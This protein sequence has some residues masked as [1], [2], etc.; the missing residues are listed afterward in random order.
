MLRLQL[1]QREK[2]GLELRE[3][4]LRAQG[5]ALR[6]LLQQLR[7]EQAH[8]M[9]DGSSG[10]SSEDPSSEEEAGEDRQQHYQVQLLPSRYLRISAIQPKERIVKALLAEPAWFNPRSI[11]GAGAVAQRVK[12][13]VAFAEDKGSS[14]SLSQCF[15]TITPA[16]EALI[17]CLLLWR[18]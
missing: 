5:P 11:D 16:L 7:W 1:A 8:L 13:L 17:P 4:A 10:G 18:P 2:R 3:A 12:A 15:N 9:G 14:P 6:L